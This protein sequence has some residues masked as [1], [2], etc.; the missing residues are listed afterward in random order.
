[1]GFFITFEGI[2]GCGKTTQIRLLGEYLE[3]LGYRVVMTREPGGCAIA[4]KIR[5][6]LLDA[7]NRELLP[8][9]ELLLYAAARAQ[10]VS[11]VIKPALAEGSIV[12][13]DRF[14]DATIAYQSAGRGIDRTTIDLLNDLACQSLVPALTVLIDC[15]PQTGLERARQRIEA[16][17]GPR[18]ER[19]ELES[20]EFHR[21][22]RNGYL[23][24]ARLEPSRVLK[25]DGSGTIA[26]IS[27][28][29]VGQV[30]NKLEVLA[31]AIR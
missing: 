17:A 19:F 25:I 14:T 21:R 3:S 31:H 13:C 5:A 28:S 4:D 7:D 26:A 27:E 16:S 8:L 22:V 9:A 1:M 30:R 12:L 2:E 10:H 15:D 23:E 24:L 29:I 18:E 6:I 11:L 20:L